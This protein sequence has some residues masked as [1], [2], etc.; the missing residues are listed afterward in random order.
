MYKYIFGISVS[1][2]M[3]ALFL[4]A[5]AATSMPYDTINAAVAS[6]KI[7]PSP[8]RGGLAVLLGSGGNITVLSGAD[9]KFLV[10]GGTALSKVRLT[11]ANDAISPQ[12]LKYLVNTHWHWDHTDGNEW[13]HD[14]GATIIARP[15]TLKDLAISYQR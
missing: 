3:L 5:R 11:A 14:L 15:Q 1:I 8:L 12:P 9:G 4:S 13:L 6:S 10:D 7:E 2:L